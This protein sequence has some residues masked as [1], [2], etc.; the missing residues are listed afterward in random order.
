MRGDPILGDVY[1]FLPAIFHPSGIGLRYSADADC[2]FRFDCFEY[3]IEW[4]NLFD[5]CGIPGI[6]IGG[7]HA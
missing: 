1:F 2:V 3:A 7:V 5:G 4:E 6:D